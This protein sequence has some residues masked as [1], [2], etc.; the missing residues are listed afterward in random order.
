MRALVHIS[1]LA[2]I[3]ALSCALMTG[4]ASAAQRSHPKAA[5]PSWMQSKQVRKRIRA[6]GEKG[7]RIGTIRRWVRSGLAGKRA[8][9]DDPPMMP[10]PTVDPSSADVYSGQCEVFPAGCSSNFIFKIGPGP[11]PPASDGRT[12]FTGTAGHCVDHSNQ[13]VFMQR[14]PTIIAVGQVKKHVNGG[15]GNDFAAIRI[16]QGLTIDPHNPAGGP[17]GIYTGCEPQGVK[18]YGHGFGVFVGQGKIEGGVATNWFQRAFAWSGA[19]LPGDSGSGVTIVGSDAAAGD[20]THLVID[21]RYPGS[22]LAG[23][24]ITRILG[25]LGGGY[26]LVNQD[27]STSRATTAD[28]ACGSANNGNGGPALPGLPGAPLP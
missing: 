18:Y 26:Y 4:A 12:A 25:F 8:Q 15:I 17:V 5:A 19:G 24:R 10:C 3:A 28:T 1:I 11:L 21:P 6:S 2:V 20:F 16:K 27:R 22:D 13:T 14:G 23:T 7:V 9:R